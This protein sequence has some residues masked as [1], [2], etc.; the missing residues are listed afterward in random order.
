MKVN[1]ADVL[2]QM[3]LPVGLVGTVGAVEGLLFGLNQDGG[4]Y[5][6]P[7]SSSQV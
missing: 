2:V 6:P 3:I 1:D 7:N 5:S 4:D